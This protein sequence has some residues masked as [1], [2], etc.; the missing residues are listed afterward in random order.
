M[1]SF[2]S[3]EDAELRIEPLCILVG[4]N[5]SGKSNA[6]DALSLLALLAEERGVADLERDE[7]E[8]AG[9]RGGIKNAAP[10]GTTEVR[11]GCTVEDDST[12]YDLDIV[13]D[14]AAEPEVTQEIL[15]ERAKGKTKVLIRSHHRHPGS[16]ISDAEVYSGSQPKVFQFLSSRLAV[17]Q[18]LTKIPADTQARTRVISACEVVTDALRGVFVLDPVPGLMRG[19]PR[20]GA[21]PDRSG[22]TTS[23]VVYSLRHD[24]EAWDKLNKLLKNLIGDRMAEI[25]FAEAT[26]P[27]RGLIDVM[28][29]LAESFAGDQQVV[30]AS[31]MSDGTLRYLSIFSTLL[32][33]GRLRNTSSSQLDQSST[34]TLVVEEIENGLYP[35]QAAGVLQLLKSEADERAV[36]LVVT[37][38]SPALLDALTPDDHGGVVVCGRSE[39]GHSTLTPLTDHANYLRLAGSGRLGSA[40]MQG[41]LTR[42]PRPTSTFLNLENS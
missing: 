20:V 24:G 13:I 27:S 9:L 12:R 1:N 41:E 10:F 15:T 29:A 22:T 21:L 33:L 14:V 36:T 2:K 28:V 16:G 4:P 7:L 26:L 19:Y 37:T 38:H 3:F 5:A 23:A 17:V 18:A 6:L 39:D 31:V 32:A 30:P 34:R 25:T 11:V 42:T 8:V 35:S 40:L